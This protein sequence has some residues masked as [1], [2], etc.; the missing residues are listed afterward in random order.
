MSAGDEGADAVAIERFG[1]V[2]AAERPLPGGWLLG[3]ALSIVVAA[4]YWL[5]SASFAILPGPLDR[6]AAARAEALES[7]A[8]IDEPTLEALAADPLA[9]RT[10][11]RAFADHCARCHG[12]RAEGGVGPNLTDA[13]WIGGGGVLD[14]YGVI[15]AGRPVAGMPAWGAELGRGTVAQLTAYVRSLRGHEVAGKPPQG[16]RWAPPSP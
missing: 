12:A 7:G 14:I 16:A 15:A 3:L 2:T 6:Y 8:L 9:V 11:A 4:G 10:G 5:A 13:Y 1:E